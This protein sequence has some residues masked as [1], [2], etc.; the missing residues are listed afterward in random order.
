MLHE[1]I[2]NV[3]ANYDNAIREKLD[4]EEN[5]EFVLFKYQVDYSGNISISKASTSLL[6]ST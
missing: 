5:A 4:L 3:L 1:E 2:A 6:N